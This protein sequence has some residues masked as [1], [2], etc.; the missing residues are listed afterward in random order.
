L[1]ADVDELLNDRFDLAPVG[2]SGEKLDT[3]CIE[4]IHME[5][6]NYI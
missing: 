4:K 5:L 2:L 1:D 3:T 6:R